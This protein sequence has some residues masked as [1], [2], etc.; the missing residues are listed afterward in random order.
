MARNL[1][2]W[3]LKTAVSLVCCQGSASLRG[4]P[5]IWFECRCEPDAKD[6][7]GIPFTVRMCAGVTL[8]GPD[9]GSDGWRLELTVKSVEIA[10]E[11]WRRFAPGRNDILNLRCW[12]RP[13]EG[14]EGVASLDGEILAREAEIDKALALSRTVLEG[15]GLLS[16]TC[17][18]YEIDLG[19][20][21]RLV[22]TLCTGEAVATHVSSSTATPPKMK[23]FIDDVVDGT[24]KEFIMATA[25][26]EY[27]LSRWV[28]V[29]F[30][31]EE[32]RDAQD[33]A[34]LDAHMRAGSP[35]R[36]KPE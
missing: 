31:D 21:R 15:H 33:E 26:T 16:S 7:K 24:R 20:G 10:D 22:G 36:N 17:P 1:I 3:D 19:R 11:A 28:L 32:D 13:G 2:R 9:R 25:D 12:E 8:F 29:K 35:A 27:K 18:S 4:G 5:G 14:L 34:G 6:W 23:S 30:G